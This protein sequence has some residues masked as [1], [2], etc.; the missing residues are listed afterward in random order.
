M[1]VGPDYGTMLSLVL[2]FFALFLLLYDILKI[3]EKGESKANSKL[4]TRRCWPIATMNINTPPTLRYPNKASRASGSSSSSRHRFFCL[5]NTSKL[6]RL[7]LSIGA[8]GLLLINNH[9]NYNGYDDNLSNNNNNNVSPPLQASSAGTVMTITTP[10]DDTT[11]EDRQLHTA[12]V[13]VVEE[14]HLDFAVVGF[15]KTGTSIIILCVLLFIPLFTTHD[16][17]MLH[18]IS[19]S[20]H[21]AQH[22]Y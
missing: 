22:S 7:I 1:P 10:G 6:L 11:K 15:E 9:Q 19:L 13:T 12:K 17:N 21:K 5:T 4:N 14:P 16:A 2:P 8:V 20:T 3:L 18:A